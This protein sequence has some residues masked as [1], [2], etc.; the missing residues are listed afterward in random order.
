IARV[1]FVCPPYS[2]DHQDL[3]NQ[4]GRPLQCFADGVL[5]VH[6]PKSATKLSITHCDS[7][8]ARC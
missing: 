6:L 4:D 1:N 7:T 3:M 5:Q 2:S 8:T